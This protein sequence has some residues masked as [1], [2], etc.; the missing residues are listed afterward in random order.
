M[1]IDADTKKQVIRNIFEH[2]W[3]QARYDSFSE[4]LEDN[5]YFTFRGVKHV[6]N[7]AEL[8]IL[9]TL[10]KTA[11]PDLT[12]QILDIIVET[13]LA[14]ANLV[15]TGTHAGEWQGIPP[16]GQKIKVAEMMFFRFEDGKIVEL[17]EVYDEAA[18]LDQLRQVSGPPTEPDRP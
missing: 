9:V 11:F 14:A 6:T 7:L 1:N 17:W 10:W 13:D 2:G 8:K 12:F 5:I 18:M 15:F 3:N 16:T 4:F